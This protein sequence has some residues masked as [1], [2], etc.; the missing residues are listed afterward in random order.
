MQTLFGLFVQLLEGKNIDKE[1]DGPKSHGNKN[2]ERLG[3]CKE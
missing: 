1:R 2:Y 3:I